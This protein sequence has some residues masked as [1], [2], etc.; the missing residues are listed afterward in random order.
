[1]PFAQLV[2]NSRM[3][4]HYR[5]TVKSGSGES[6][7][8]RVSEISQISNIGEGFKKMKH[9]QMETLKELRQ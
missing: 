6:H 7:K 1:M 9:N 5:G 8:K 4:K 2:P 3:N